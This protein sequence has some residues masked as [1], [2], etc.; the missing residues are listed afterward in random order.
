MLTFTALLTDPFGVLVVWFAG[1]QNVFDNLH[2]RISYESRMS[3]S[4]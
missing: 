2:V 3:M 1:S 4:P